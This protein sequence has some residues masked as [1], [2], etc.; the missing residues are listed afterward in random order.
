MIAD[1]I[2]GTGERI[3]G[4][5]LS[6]R[7][8]PGRGLAD[9]L[10]EGGYFYNISG[11]RGFQNA[12]A[13]AAQVARRHHDRVALLTARVSL[14]Y[15]LNLQNPVIR[16]LFLNFGATFERRIKQL[17]LRVEPN[18]NN[19]YYRPLSHLKIEAF[20]RMV[21]SMA[22]HPIDVLMARFS[23]K[24]PDIDDD[25][26]HELCVKR[27]RAIIGMSACDPAT[28]HGL[29]SVDPT[30]LPCKDE[31]IRAAERAATTIERFADRDL[32]DL[33]ASIYQGSDRYWA[34][35]RLRFAT[36][37]DVHFFYDSRLSSHGVRVRDRLTAASVGR[38]ALRTCDLAHFDDIG[39][40]LAQQRIH[41]SLSKAAGV[42][43]I[44]GGADLEV[45]SILIT[46]AE[47]R[48][49][50]PVLVLLDVQQGCDVASFPLPMVL[51]SRHNLCCIALP[52]TQCALDA[53]LVGYLHDRWEDGLKVLEIEPRMA[54]RHGT[55]ESRR[56]DARTIVEMYHAARP[57]S[58]I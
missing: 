54:A 43:A 38:R 27:A 17:G 11:D 32:V 20:R 51:R 3:A 24:S 47:R 26:P 22:Q 44:L 28:D 35:E 58:L 31:T 10:G 55:P 49:E 56:A 52:Q 37:A 45:L 41:R 50:L 36:D 9:Y 4:L 2:H 16:P 40:S 21:E 48:P 57:A 8:R 13:H 42:V 23:K 29:C 25:L 15:A 1:V 6:D 18:N 39:T 19:T 33:I 34:A 53:I 46:L 14:E 12:V 5:I 7:F 30:A